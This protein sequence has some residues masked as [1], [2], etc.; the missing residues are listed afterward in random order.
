MSLEGTRYMWLFVFFDL[1]VKTKDERGRANK[2]RR[3]LLQDGYLMM[4][5]SVYARI[6]NGRERLDKHVKRLEGNIPP[7]GSVRYFE[8]TDKQYG[9]MKLLVGKPTNNEKNRAKQLLLF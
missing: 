6:C 2:F 1:P 8:L 5:L 9:R 3:F 7:A 4:Q